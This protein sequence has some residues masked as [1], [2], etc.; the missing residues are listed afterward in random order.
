MA[1]AAGRDASELA[2][3]GGEDYELLF[4]LPAERWDEAAAACGLPL[5]RLGR[6][7][8]GEGLSLVGVA[9][10]DLRGYEHL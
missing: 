10:A 1:R 2:A 9:A 4:T 8:A 6:A 3:T 7:V 5:S